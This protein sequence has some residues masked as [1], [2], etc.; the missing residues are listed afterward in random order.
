[1]TGTFIKDFQPM[2]YTVSKMLTMQEDLKLKKE[3]QIKAVSFVK[4]RYPQHCELF[5]ELDDGKQFMQLY[6]EREGGLLPDGCFVPVLPP[7]GVRK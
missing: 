3:F 4:S 2:M 7:A 6:T 5:V 1:M